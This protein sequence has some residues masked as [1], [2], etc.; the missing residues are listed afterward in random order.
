MHKEQDIEKILEQLKQ[1]A[2]NLKTCFQFML[3]EEHDTNEECV[4]Q[5]WNVI[6]SKYSEGIHALLISLKEKIQWTFLNDRKAEIRGIKSDYRSTFIL[7]KEY[8]GI[9]FNNLFNDILSLLGEGENGFRQSLL[10]DGYHEK[11]FGKHLDDYRLGNEARLTAIYIQDSADRAF[12]YPD[13]NQRKVFMLD[14]RRKELFADKVG[15]IFHDNRR[16]IKSFVAEIIDNN[17][18]DYCEKDIFS[19]FDKYLAFII[20][21]EFCNKKEEER[22]FKNIIFKENVDVDKVIRKLDE[23]VDNQTISAQKHWYIVYKVFL[24]KDWLFKNN[25]TKFRDQIN[26]ALGSKLKC[27]EEDFRAIEKYYKITDYSKWTIQD[28]KA[29]SCCEAYKKIADE[30]DSEF[31]EKKYALPGK[32]INTRKIEKL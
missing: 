5:A 9:E 12:E 30:L 31:D 3:D 32:K 11:L 28:N 2:G 21:E 10:V 22:T 7:S 27:T 25:Q 29:P 8:L 13:D 4:M 18:K 16:D 24:N 1:K 14:E 6:I 19:F 15:K 23:Y 26:S 17:G 20:A